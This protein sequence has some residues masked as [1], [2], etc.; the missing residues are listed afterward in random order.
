MKNLQW[1]VKIEPLITYWRRLFADKVRRRG[2]LALAPV[3]FISPTAVMTTINYA[4]VYREL[5]ASG[6]SRKES[7]IGAIRGAET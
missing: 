1:E 3:L 2:W 6:L 7:V 4:R 5:T